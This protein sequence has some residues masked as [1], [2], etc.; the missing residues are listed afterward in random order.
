MKPSL[1]S[2]TIAEKRLELI[3]GLKLFI[4]T[5]DADITKLAVKSPSRDNRLNDIRSIK[6]VHA[7]GAHDRGLLLVDLL[8]AFLANLGFEVSN[9]LRRMRRALRSILFTSMRPIAQMATGPSSVRTLGQSAHRESDPAKATRGAISSCCIRGE[10][11]S[12]GI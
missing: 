12:D 6:T 3:K 9:G 2:L 4:R 1:D 8:C 5:Q 7:V 11:Q 10:S